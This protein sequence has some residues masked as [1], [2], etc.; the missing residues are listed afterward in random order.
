MH[1]LLIAVLIVAFSLPRADVT[2]VVFVDAN[3]NGVRDAGETGI[4]NVAV[5]NQDV[6]TRHRC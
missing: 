1:R 3:A 6:V 2:G 4:A 5:S